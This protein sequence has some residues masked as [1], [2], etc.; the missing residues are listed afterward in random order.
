MIKV[1]L[2]KPEQK[3]ISGSDLATQSDF[4]EVKEEKIAIPGAIIVAVLTVGIIGFLYITQAN[5]LESKTKLLSEKKA[6]KTKLEAQLKDI[7]KLKALKA[8]LQLRI[9]TIKDLK[10]KQKQPVYMML[11]ISKNIPERVWINKLNF[12]GNRISIYGTALSQNLIATFTKN[13]E[14]SVFFTNLIWGGFTKKNQKGVEI[15][16]FSFNVDFV[17]SSIK[18]GV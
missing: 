13:I 12:N 3:D 7:G 18:E 16:T 2:L 17:L 6:E 5:E 1:N 9:K 14:S 15:F 10:K 8:E 11:E 4:M